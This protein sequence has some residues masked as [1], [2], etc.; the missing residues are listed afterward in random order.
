MAKVQNIS[1]ISSNIPFTEYNFCDFYRSTFKQTELGRI[2]ELIP[3]TQLVRDFGLIRHNRHLCG[4][5]PFL[6]L[7]AKSRQLFSIAAGTVIVFSVIGKMLL[8]FGTI[9]SMYI[10]NQIQHHVDLNKTGNILILSITLNT[11]IGGIAFTYG[12]LL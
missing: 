6:L 2:Y 9:V 3:F 11:D 8:L 4:K 7:K 10:Q 5:K 1:T 12:V